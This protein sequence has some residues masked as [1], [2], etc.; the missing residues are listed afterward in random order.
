MFTDYSDMPS[1]A[2]LLQLFLLALDIV[3]IHVIFSSVFCQQCLLC[4]NSII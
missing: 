3:D 4:C 1:F 2:I